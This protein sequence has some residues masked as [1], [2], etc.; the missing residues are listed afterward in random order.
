MKGKERGREGM[1]FEYRKSR[2]TVSF[3]LSSKT[4]HSFKRNML[5]PRKVGNQPLSKMKCIA[6]A[7]AIMKTDAGG[8]FTAA[9][10]K[11][12]GKGLSRRAR[13]MPTDKELQELSSDNTPDINA[14]QTKYERLKQ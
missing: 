2:R 5:P 14:G 8:S 3:D 12:K 13:K 9:K 1:R 10:K 11:G 6:I 7:T 4:G